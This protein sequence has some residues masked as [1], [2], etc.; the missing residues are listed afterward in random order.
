[1]VQV[2][3]F[4]ADKREE[5]HLRAWEIAQ[6]NRAHALHAEKLASVPEYH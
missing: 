1:M 4:L 2:K 6:R 5:D 3:G